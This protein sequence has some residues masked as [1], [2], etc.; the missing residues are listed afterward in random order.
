M[1]RCSPDSGSLPNRRIDVDPPAAGAAASR[2]RRIAGQSRRTSSPLTRV[3]PS[4]TTKATTAY[5][6]GFMAASH[7]DLGD[8]PD[9]EEAD[10]LHDEARAEEQ[11]RQGGLHHGRE[12]ARVQQ[13]EDHGEGDRAD[14]HADGRPAVLGREGTRMAQDLEPLA[15]HLAQPIQDLREVP[16]RAALDGDGGAEEPDVVRRR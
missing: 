9:H 7:L 3:T 12:V 2:S 15:D 5:V 4:T 10:G 1:A 8:A 13:L 6:S 11:G 14:P 16:A